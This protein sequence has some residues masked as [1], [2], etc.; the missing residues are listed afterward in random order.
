M[1]AENPCAVPSVFSE[2]HD[3]MLEAIWMV[4]EKGSHALADVRAYI[5]QEGFEDVLGEIFEKNLARIEGDQVHFSETGR[6]RARD[7]IRR[8]R[9]A[10]RLLIDVLQTGWDEIEESACQLE[11]ILSDGVVDKICTLLGHPKEC[12]HGLAMPV[13]ACCQSA[14]KSVESVIM[15][16][17]KANVGED[18]IL[19]YILTRDNPR[20]HK[21]M[22]FGM[23]PGVRVKVVQKSPSYV[24]KVGETQIA[25]ESDIVKDIYIRRG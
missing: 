15:P 8:H 7:L 9:L 5:L 10:E 14:D 2:A 12:P 20:L 22:S 6:K 3:E 23:A 17:T 13:G 1:K 19:A 21:L 16:M 4:E 11:H 18:V 25:L 24:L